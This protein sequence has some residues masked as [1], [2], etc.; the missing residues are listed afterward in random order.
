MKC[1]WPFQNG[2]EELIFWIFKML[3]TTEE[4]K[5][6]IDVLL[7]DDVN[8]LRNILLIFFMYSQK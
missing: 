7:L 6:E 3:S 8:V 5:I 4:S 2:L 1:M